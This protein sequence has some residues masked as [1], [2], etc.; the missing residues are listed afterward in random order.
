MNSRS[1]LKSPARWPSK[2]Q[3]F[4]RSSW[5]LLIPALFLIALMHVFPFVWQMQLAFTDL[6][7]GTESEYIGFGNFRFLFTS[8]GFLASFG[9]TF[10]F[11]FGSVAGRMG[12]GLGLAITMDQHLRFRT[13]YRVL[14]LLPWIV[15]GVVVGFLFRAA[16]AESSYGLLN[17]WLE[18]LG[19]GPVKW[20]S[21]PWNA[22]LSVIFSDIWRGVGFATVLQLAGLQ[23]V[24]KDLLE[25]AE[26]D[27]AGAF[28]KL[29]RIK[30]PMMRDIWSVALVFTVIGAFDTYE[31]IL[32]LTGGGPGYAT[33]T[34]ALY[35][36]QTAFGEAFLFGRGAAVG[37]LLFFV[38]LVFVLIYVHLS[39]FGEKRGR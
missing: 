27:G 8:P 37:V 39:G 20:R 12:L 4:L 30:L 25:C 24:P 6:R 17:A 35:M 21:V 38:T 14:I 9:F 26:I 18:P 31:Q 10:L 36:F 5:P 11:M 13:L 19:L 3:A 22:R 7:L 34:M 29:V 2:L 32:V 23:T 1:S 16:M 28:R 15:A 33:T